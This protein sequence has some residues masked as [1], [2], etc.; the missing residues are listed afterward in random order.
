M[1]LGVLIIMA[2]VAVSLCMG[3][4]VTISFPVAVVHVVPPAMLLFAFGYIKDMLTKS[5]DIYERFFNLWMVIFCGWMSI[6][7]SV[8]LGKYYNEGIIPTASWTELPEILTWAAIGIGVGLALH[9]IV[10][11]LRMYPRRNYSGPKYHNYR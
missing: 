1:L 6:S 8:A 9:F 5:K 4:G 7:G 3:I 2:I 11:R 10:K